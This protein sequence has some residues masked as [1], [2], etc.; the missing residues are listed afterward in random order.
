M[1]TTR[2]TDLD[3]SRAYFKK[4][5]SLDLVTEVEDETGVGPVG[6]AGVRQ[7]MPSLL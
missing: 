2:T 5:V 1:C 6:D 3:D 7:S 4:L